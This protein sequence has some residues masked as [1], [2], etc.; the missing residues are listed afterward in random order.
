MENFKKIYRNKIKRY[1]N[2]REGA[3]RKFLFL[4][5]AIWSETCGWFWLRELTY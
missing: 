4:G 3:K 2:Y 5:Q 1:N